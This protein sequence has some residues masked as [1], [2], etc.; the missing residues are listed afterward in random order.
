MQSFIDLNKIC[1]SSFI[2]GLIAKGEG[3]QFELKKEIPSVE[4]LARLIAG[5]ANADGGVIYVGYDEKEGRP[6]GLFHSDLLRRRVEMAAAQ[7]SITASS[8]SVAVVPYKQTQLGV[9]VV[10]PVPDGPILYKG[11]AFR[12]LGTR[13]GDYSPKEFLASATLVQEPPVA[14]RLS[15]GE[16]DRFLKEADEDS[17][18]DLLIVPLLRTFGFES[19]SRKGHRDKSLEFGKDLRGIKY[20]LPTGHWLYFAAQVKVGNIGYSAGKT[21][22]IGKI[23]EQLRAALRT[24]MMDWQARTEHRPDH[25]FLAASGSIAEGAQRYLAEQICDDQMRVLFWDRDLIVDACNARGLPEAI[26]RDIN[27]YLETGGAG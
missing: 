26:Q 1:T 21:N 18:T 20:K 2:D 3:Q 25:V 13:I 24:K 10:A 22:S 23:E 6:T 19:I 9:I 16:L 4:A 27:R 8:I 12:R 15:Q 11:R 7:L 17:L 5:F 14:L